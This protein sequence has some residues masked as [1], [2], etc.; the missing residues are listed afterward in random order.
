MM[1]YQ[2]TPNSVNNFQFQPMLDGSSY[3]V[4]LTWNVFGQRYYVNIYDQSFGL[5]VCLP[6]IGSPID[7]NISMTAGYF[8]SQLI[9]RPDL[10]QFQVI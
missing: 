9:Y 6:L 2:F 5:I 3:V 10:Q 1:T 8:T 4:M 7:K